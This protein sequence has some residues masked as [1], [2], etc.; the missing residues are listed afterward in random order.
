MQRNTSRIVW[1][2]NMHVGSLVLSSP[3]NGNTTFNIEITRLQKFKRQK[4][5]QNHD[6][7]L[8]GQNHFVYVDDI[9]T[10]EADNNDNK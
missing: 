8:A 2:N 6:F 9:R 3:A 7:P 4:R 10:D 5:W 1:K